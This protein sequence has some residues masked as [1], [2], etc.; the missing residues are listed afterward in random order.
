MSC[1]AVLT[2]AEGVEPF[3]VMGLAWPQELPKPRG[4]DWGV[5]LGVGP[6]DPL[7][8]LSGLQRN[9]AM[10]TLSHHTTVEAG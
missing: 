2:V 8:F 10:H 9:N 6:L 4:V 7:L 3:G 1:R 5:P